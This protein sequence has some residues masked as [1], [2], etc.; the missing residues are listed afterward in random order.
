M[1]RIALP[2]CVAAAFAAGAVAPAYGAEHGWYVGTGIGY[3]TASIPDN[4]VYNSMSVVAPG[5][6]VLS[7][8]RND[9]SLMYQLFLGYSFTS[10]LAL[11]ANA[12]R[13]GEF[14]FTAATSSTT[15]VGTDLDMWGGSLDLLGII[16]L[17]DSWRVYGRVGAA[18]IQSTAKYS[19]AGITASEDTETSVGWKAGVGVGYEFESGVAFR[20]EY[21]YYSV[22]TALGGGKVNTQVFS[23]TALYR[24][25]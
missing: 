22:D 15:G 25:K 18:V 24:F 3:S 16:P 21:N 12:F 9:D 17:G 5:Q 4:A 8:T 10:F 14:G 23:G 7:I 2:V 19:G 13:L 1:K 20:A 11:E 6:P